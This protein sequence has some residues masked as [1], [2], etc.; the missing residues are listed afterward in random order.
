MREDE[1]GNENEHDLED[2]DEDEIVEFIENEGLN[3][4]R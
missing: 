2:M 1:V 3:T 4:K